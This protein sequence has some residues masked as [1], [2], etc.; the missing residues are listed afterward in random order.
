ME[1]MGIA[2]DI[3]GPRAGILTADGGSLLLVVNGGGGSLRG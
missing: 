1:R 2:R 3:A